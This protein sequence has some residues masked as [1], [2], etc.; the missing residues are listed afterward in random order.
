MTPRDHEG[1]SV[2]GIEAR[3]TNA[4]ELTPEGAIADLWQRFRA[5]SLP[6][7]VPHRIGHS[8]FAVYTDYASDENGEYTILV[9]VRTDPA[10]PPPEGMVV[11]HVPAGRYGV[12]P[13][14]RGP[15]WEVVPQA[16]AT[17]STEPHTRAFQ[18]DFELYDERAAN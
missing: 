16:W 13:T 3:T 8:V 15:V 1:F 11:R 18:T 2:T 9:G 7:R 5:E 12:F 4:R 10:A 17:L 6:D 14:A